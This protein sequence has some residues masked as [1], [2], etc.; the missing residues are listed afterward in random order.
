M[1]NAPLLYGLIYVS[2]SV[3][4]INLAKSRSPAMCEVTSNQTRFMM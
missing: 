3:H 2:D 4:G 1:L